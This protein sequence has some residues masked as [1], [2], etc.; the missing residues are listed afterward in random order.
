MDSISTKNNNEEKNK[1]I[2]DDNYV[3][4]NESFNILIAISWIIIIIVALC[5]LLGLTY[6]YDIIVYYINN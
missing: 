2:N 1:I 6:I 5:L 3:N 4:A